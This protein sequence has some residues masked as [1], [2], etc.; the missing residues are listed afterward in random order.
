MQKRQQTETIQRLA[1]AGA[2]EQAYSLVEIFPGLL[3]ELHRLVKERAPKR[4]M[5][6]EQR[7]ELAAAVNGD[8]QTRK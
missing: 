3:T 6:P 2:L 5:S 7:A 1:F 8:K 4:R